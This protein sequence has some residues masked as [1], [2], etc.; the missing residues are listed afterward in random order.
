MRILGLICAA[1]LGSCAARP[2][3][4]PQLDRVTPDPEWEAVFTRTDGW[5]GADGA[6]TVQLPGGRL[7]WLFG[8]TFIGPVREG[9]H[10]EG[11]AMVNNTIAVTGVGE[12]G[13]ERVS[14]AWGGRPEKPGAWVAPEGRAE[15]GAGV[16]TELGLWFWPASGGF[17]APGADGRERLVLFMSRMSRRDGGEGV[18]NFRARGT[19]VVMV[20]NPG[21][22]PG[23]W[24]MTQ[25]ELTTLR[26]GGRLLMWGTGAVVIGGEA[27][28]VGIDE[29]NVFDKKLV[30]ARAPAASVERF[31]TW[32][33]WTGRAWSEREEEA[34]AVADGLS[35][36]VSL[37]RMKVRG[38]DA[39]VLVYSEGLLGR[40]ILARTMADP[41][42][43]L[44]VGRWSEAV[45][46][47]DCPEPV[48]D[49]RMM[50]YSAKAHPEVSR[51]GEFLVSY[52]VNSTDFWDV[53]AN[54]AKYRPR[55]VRVPAGMLP[56][57]P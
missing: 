29:T 38:R 45:R 49:A 4:E 21:E 42:E 22:E 47:Y 1:V 37:H 34:A 18:W 44:A 27:L 16:G 48:E 17:V 30:M 26:E 14:F 19:S 13:M 2:A 23:R 56:G 51:R 28:I 40:G 9:R 11:T 5:T 7:L 6:A 10:A 43:G 46:L 31:G 15:A 35:S 24:R 25:R 54:A 3:M 50:A 41:G 12:R 57:A 36:E 32:R 55:F 20:S 33:F 39:L 52:S 8:D 53:V